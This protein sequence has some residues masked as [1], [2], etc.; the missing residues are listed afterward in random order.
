MAS[1]AQKKPKVTYAPSSNYDATPSRSAIKSIAGRMRA[2][3]EYTCDITN[4]WKSDAA[5]FDSLNFRNQIE[6]LASIHKAF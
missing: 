1:S 4:S 6:V 2:L 3:G 5:F